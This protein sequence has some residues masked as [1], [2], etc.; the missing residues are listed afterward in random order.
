MFF[1]PVL[2]AYKPDISSSQLQLT[3]SKNQHAYGRVKK[4]KRE[5]NGVV[6]RSKITAKNNYGKTIKYDDSQSAYSLS[7]TGETFCLLTKTLF[8]KRKDKKISSLPE[9]KIARKNESNI[10]LINLLIFSILLSI[11]NIFF[12]LKYT[13]VICMPKILQRRHVIS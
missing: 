4:R 7:R 2:V 5:K 13:V 11:K 8:F 10:Q 12:Y 3:V 6:R 1:R 9:Y